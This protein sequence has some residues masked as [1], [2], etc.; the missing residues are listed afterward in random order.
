VGRVVL[1]CAGYWAPLARLLAGTPGIE[2]AAR[3]QDVRADAQ[4]ALLSL[5]LLLGLGDSAFAP[6]PRYLAAPADA[7]SRW[8]ARVA[9]HRGV[10]VGLCWSGNARRADPYASR[11]DARRSL[12]LAHLAPLRDV[13][14]VTFFNLRKDG[15]TAQDA[16]ALPLVDWSADLADYAE[17][18]ALMEALD[19]VISVDTS[20]VHCAGALG[21]PVWMLDRFDNCWRWGTDAASPGWYASLRVFRQ[22]RFGEWDDVVTDVRNALERFVAERPRAESAPDTPRD[23]RLAP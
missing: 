20:V 13:P 17:T 5:P 6:R 4:C 21:R 7:V 9:A 3:E 19:L 15:L 2:I 11:I 1:A 10:R 8:R 14:G 12:P 18:A 16:A 22:S 23:A